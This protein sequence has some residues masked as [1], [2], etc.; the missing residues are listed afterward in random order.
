MKFRRDTK[1][2]Q[3]GIERKPT[4][5]ELRRHPSGGEFEVESFSNK[6]FKFRQRGKGDVKCIID[7]DVSEHNS[8]IVRGEFKVDMLERQAEGTCMLNGFEF[9]AVSDKVLPK[10]TEREVKSKME[11]ERAA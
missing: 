3:H 1:E 9:V 5:I 6:K 10:K 7:S 4:Q 2:H 11:I 8:N